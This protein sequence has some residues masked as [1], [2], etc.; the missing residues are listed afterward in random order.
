MPRSLL[1]AVVLLSFVDVSAAAESVDYL[2]EIKPLLQQKCYACHGAFQQKAKLRV[3]TAASLITGGE[4]GPAIVA[5]QP[6]ASLLIQ[7][8]TGKAG[9]RMPPE[10]E[11]APLTADE[12][13]KVVSWIKAGAPVPLDEKPQVD[14]QK[15]WSYVAVLRPEVPIVKNPNWVKTPIDAFIAHEHEQRGLR[16]RS[17]A[18][19]ATWLRRVTLDLIGLPPTRKELHAFVADES[20]GAFE[21]VVDELLSRPQYGERWGR[22]WMDIWRYSDWY[23]SRG[24]N[25]IRYSQRH[26]WRWRDWI[27]DSLNADKSYDRML[28]EM[29][30]GD[31]LPTAEPSTLAATGFLGRNWYKFDRNVWMFETVERTSEAF[32]GLTLKCCRCHDHKFDPIAQLDY[33]QFRAIFEPH[34]VR[35]DKLSAFVETEKDA[36][37]G[38]V[39]KDGVARVFDKEPAVAT[40]RFIRGDDRLPEKDKPL[41]PGVPPAIGGAAFKVE[42][43][44]LTLDNFYPALRPELRESLVAKAASDVVQAKAVFEKSEAK[45]AATKAVLADFEKKTQPSDAATPP[46]V[47][48]SDNFAAARP[49][50]WQILDGQWVYEDGHLTQ[51]SV[52]TFATIVTKKPHPESFRAKLKYRVL[53]P[54]TFRSIGFSFDFQD[55]GNS[56]DVYTSSGDARK[57]VQAFHRVGGAQH[58][59]AAGIKDVTLK[60]GDI[61]TLEFTVK[62]SKLTIDLNGERK[63]DY[64]LPVARR[65]GKFAMWAHAGVAEFLECEIRELLPSREQLLAEVRSAEHEHELARVRIEIAETERVSIEKRITAEL[66]KYGSTNRET[67]PELALAASAAE[68]QVAAWQARIKVLEAEFLLSKYAGA[69]AVPEKPDAAKLDAEKK[70]AAAKTALETATQ[71]AKQPD[72]KYEPLGEVFPAS[73]TGRRFALANWIA[74]DRNPRTARVAVNHIWGRHFGQP[75]VATPENFGLNGASPTHPALLDWLASELIAN[76]WRMKPLHRAI[77]LSATYRQSSADEDLTSPIPSP[78]SLDPSNLYLWRMNSRRMEAEVVRDSVLSLGNALDLKRGGPEIPEAQGQDVPRRSLYFRNTPNEKMPFLEVFDVAD[79]NSCYRRKES[80]IPQQALAIMNGALAQ[81]QSRAI[82]ETLS[83]EVGLSNDAETRSKFIVAAF[84]QVLTRGA[85]SVE[86]DRCQRFLDEHYQLVASGTKTAYSGNSGS[87][88]PAATDPAMRARESLIQV[89]LLHNDFVTIR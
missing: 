62:G 40:Y 87:K 85:T 15:Y 56:Q 83:R 34:N 11:A 20:D 24:I 54:G 39:L 3:D 53:Q 82:A 48:L 76:G 79:P 14:P 9:F 2:R 68:R 46:D 80:V 52:A 78:Q 66:A 44:A 84:E 59:P 63:L 60:V 88:R 74:S 12:L 8:L 57:T 27:V 28:V 17:A 31:E 7:A 55:K 86:I 33:Y 49:D 58:Y 47:F 4:T 70:L 37:L 10:G 32:L 51:K 22:H 42:P 50:D 64:V 13:A 43:V 1:V 81:D 41:G 61:T 38:L 89:L 16:P 72:S 21:R 25:E 65:P 73:S 18:D 29:L 30:A 71:A 35:T 6:E 23:G 67:P 45:I 69:A 77:V 19:R 75:L 26:I 36:T 5:G